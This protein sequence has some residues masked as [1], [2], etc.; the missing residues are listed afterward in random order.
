MRRPFIILAASIVLLGACSNGDRDVLTQDALEENF[1]EVL[2]N[3]QVRIDNESLDRSFFVTGE[4]A[5][6]NTD[7][8]VAFTSSAYEELYNLYR[9]D[10]SSK[11]LAD[12]MET[13]TIELYREGTE[14]E[15][16]DVNLTEIEVTVPDTEQTGYIYS[17]LLT[18]TTS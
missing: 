17:S 10:Y 6:M 1:E 18:E 8:F 5:Q 9:V 7:A 3:T 4:T 14:V 12:I 15:V 11:Q 2:T 16:V 13:N